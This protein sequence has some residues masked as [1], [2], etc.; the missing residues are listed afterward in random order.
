M[1]IW[2]FQKQS[3][4]KS[5]DYTTAESGVP[6]KL[7]LISPFKGR[8]RL[9]LYPSPPIMVRYLNTCAETYIRSERKQIIPAI[10]R[11]EIT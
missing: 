5:V 8:N 6:Q 1:Y 11:G 9:I 4:D 2:G 3:C 7:P 10:A